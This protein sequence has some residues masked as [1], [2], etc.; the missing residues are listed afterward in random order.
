MAAGEITRYISL[1]WPQK[2]SLPIFFNLA[3]NFD[4]TLAG[5][6]SWPAIFKS[7]DPL[8]PFFHVLNRL[9]S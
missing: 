9:P 5:F 4:L 6:I 1:P 3:G 2:F 7:K 8:S